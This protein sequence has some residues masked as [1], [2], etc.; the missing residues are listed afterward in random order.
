MHEVK[1]KDGQVVDPF[2]GM[3]GGKTLANS[4]ML[5]DLLSGQYQRAQSQGLKL[6]D[7]YKDKTSFHEREDCVY[8][9][10]RVCIVIN[11][12][13]SG[14]QPT[15]KAARYTIVTREDEY[16]RG[17]FT[18]RPDSG[19]NCL[20]DGPTRASPLLWPG[21]TGLNHNDIRWRRAAFYIHP[22]RKDDFIRTVCGLLRL[23]ELSD[24]EAKLCDE[25]NNRYTRIDS[26]VSEKAEI[27]NEGSRFEIF[28]FENTC[29]FGQ[30]E[31][32]VRTFS[33]SETGVRYLHTSGLGPCIAVSFYDPETRTGAMLHADSK[34]DL[35]D[36][37]LRIKRRLTESSS[38]RPQIETTGGQ[39]LA[40]HVR[41]LMAIEDSGFS[42]EQVSALRLGTYKTMNIGMDLKDGRIFQSPS[43]NHPHLGL[44]AGNK[45]R[46]VDE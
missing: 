3:G 21:E 32:A 19:I 20:V 45:A 29:V 42:L 43:G 41:V 40:E 30:R 13:L 27:W 17:V 11:K 39:C 38:S 23:P 26:L 36:A 44:P 2:A 35:L 16:T 24:E 18:V 12:D 4:E 1:I 14:S 34:V 33:D 6:P 25:Y 10:D 46:F 7:W 15:S 22:S 31:M 28:Q 9:D 37:F 8:S 5:A